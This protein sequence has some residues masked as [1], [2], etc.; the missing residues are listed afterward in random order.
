MTT[1][2]KLINSLT[3]ALMLALILVQP[4]S[5]DGNESTKSGEVRRTT[6]MV[7]ETVV[8]SYGTTT[9][10]CREEIVEEIIE[11]PES[12]DLPQNTGIA[13][14]GMVAGS[15]LAGGAGLMTLAR[16]QMKY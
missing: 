12:A 1:K 14:V 6:K 15:L 16:Q 13:Q 7:C 3:T 9:E 8:G 2:Q 10:N 11:R 5:A 4:V